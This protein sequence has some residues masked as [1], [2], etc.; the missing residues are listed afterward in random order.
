MVQGSVE[1]TLASVVDQLVKAGY[2]DTVSGER[3][4]VRSAANGT[5][6]KPEDLLIE[7]VERLEGATDPDEEVIVMAIRARLLECRGTYVLPF[8]KDM[9]SIDAALVARIP[10]IRK[11]A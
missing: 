10:D 1:R 5:M 4:G 9:P 2:T 8:G 3:E 11:S 7:R 6:F